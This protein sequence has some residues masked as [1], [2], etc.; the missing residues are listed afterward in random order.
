MS[1]PETD[2]IGEY[3]ISCRDADEY[4]AMF[5]LTSTDL[6]GSVL[7]CPG[8]GSS[9]TL[10]ADLVR[11]GTAARVRAVDH[12]FQRGAGRMLELDARC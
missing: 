7:D 3:L 8:G 4:Q 1:A 11:T 2:S 10:L 6:V 9:C 12:E 5:A